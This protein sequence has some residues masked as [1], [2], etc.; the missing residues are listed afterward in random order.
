M[1]IKL[2]KGGGD[3][4]NQV[5]VPMFVVITLKQTEYIVVHYLRL[6]IYCVIIVILIINTVTVCCSM[7]IRIW[8]TGLIYGYYKVIPSL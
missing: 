6:F 1:E 8:K 3:H 5:A 2:Y 4:Q 7:S